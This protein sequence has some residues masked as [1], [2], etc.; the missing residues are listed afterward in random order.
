[1]ATSEE[2]QELVE[3]LKGPRFY[4]VTISGYGGESAYMSINK[5]AFEFWNPITEE[6]G[7]SDLTNYMVNAE[8]GD[9]EFEDIEQV[10]DSADFLKSADADGEVWRSP[11]YEAPTEFEHSWGVEYNSA[12]ITVDEVASDDYSAKWVADVIENVNIC[13][14]IDN[15][16]LDIEVEMD[17]CSEAPDGTE[18]I[19]QM[20]SSEKGQFFDGVIETVGDF[21]INKLK[22]Y[23]MEYMNGEDTITSVEYNGVE[24]DN[25]GGDTNGKGYY[26]A[27]WKA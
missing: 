24:I 9:F 19:A 27:V 10:P 2:K 6:N 3:E 8:D 21:D 12:N 26:G 7:D 16:E 14:S 22:I 15:E 18:Y 4:H 13:D 11:W 23:T 17:V 1:M 20:Y 5:E 25:Q